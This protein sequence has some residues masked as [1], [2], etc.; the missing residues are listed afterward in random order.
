VSSVKEKIKSTLSQQHPTLISYVFIEPRTK[1]CRL[2]VSTLK[3]SILTLACSRHILPLQFFE[4]PIISRGFR[5]PSISRHDV[6]NELRK[7][8]VEIKSD[9]MDKHHGE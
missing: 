2:E 9:L 7:M 4:D 6:R 5:L 1:K 3:K 8:T